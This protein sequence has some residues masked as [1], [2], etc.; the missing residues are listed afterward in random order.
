VT[1]DAA[2][3]VRLRDDSAALIRP[4]EPSDAALVKALYH[5]MSDLSRRLRFLVPTT[6]ISDEDVQYLTDVDHRR[7]EALIA[8]DPERERALGVARYVRTPGDREAAEVAVVVVDDWHRRGLGTALLDRLTERARENGIARYTAVVSA[9]NDIVL[10]ALER[11]GA[12]LTGRS[13]DGEIEFAI[14]LPS[15]GLGDRLRGALRV[16]AASQLEFLAQALKRL[17]VWRRR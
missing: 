13:D 15:E 1:T 7:H 2:A 3:E 9:D 5:E 4:I 16:A 10:A 12:E 6:D 11:A 14:D 8:L 17:R